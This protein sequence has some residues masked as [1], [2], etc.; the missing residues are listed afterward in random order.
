MQYLIFKH[1][2]V[3]K[4]RLRIFKCLKID[5]LTDKAGQYVK[6]IFNYFTELMI[7]KKL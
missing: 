7:D 6:Q 2:L 5:V 3:E 1:A 4:V